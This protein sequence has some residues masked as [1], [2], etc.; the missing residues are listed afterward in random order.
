MLPISKEKNSRV[1]GLEIINNSQG[2][3]LTHLLKFNFH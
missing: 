1:F 2:H 3:C